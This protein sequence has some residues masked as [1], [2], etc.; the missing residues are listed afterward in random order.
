MFLI[1]TIY[2]LKII[3]YYSWLIFITLIKVLTLFCWNNT[4]FS[5]KPPSKKAIFV[6]I[7]APLLIIFLISGYKYA[8][9]SFFILTTFFLIYF[10]I[11]NK[12]L[13]KKYILE[14]LILNVQLL[15]DTYS[16]FYITTS[17]FVGLKKITSFFLALSIIIFLIMFVAPKKI[18]YI[19]LFRITLILCT[20]L[21]P[22]F[23]T[24]STIIDYKKK[25]TN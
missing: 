8:L 11:S 1:I 18:L 13:M 16:F 21:I 2:Y 15:A 22:L 6:L 17:F 7:S 10:K 19:L 24:Y 12:N 4:I 5:L 14:T 25:N 9:P 20:N 3:I 23:L